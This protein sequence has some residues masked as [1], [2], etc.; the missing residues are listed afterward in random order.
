LLADDT[1]HLVWLYPGPDGTF[2]P[3]TLPEDSFRPLEDWVDYVIATNHAPLSAWVEAS[4]F[5]FEHFVCAEGGKPPR[6]PGDGGKGRRRAKADDTPTPA[7][8]PKTA[9]PKASDPRS[10][11]AMVS[12]PVEAKKPGEWEVRRKE[13]QDEFLSYDG[14]LDIPERQALWPALA[15]ANAGAN[16]R[17]E[18]ALCWINDLWG[19]GDA[20]CEWAEGWLRSELRDVTLPITAAE[21]DR[22]LKPTDPKESQTRQF[23]AALYWLTSQEPIPGWLANRLPA[24]K[25]YLEANERKLPIRANWLVSSRLAGLTGA[26]TLGLARVRDR[27]LQRLLDEGIHAERDLPFFLRSAGLKNSDRLRQVRAMAIELHQSVRSW[28]ESS[29][30]APPASTQSDQGATL[31]YIDLFFAFALAKLGEASA[32]RQ[33]VESAW[34]LLERF[35]PDED[36]GIAARFL[37]QAFKYRVEQALDG[38]PHTGRLSARLTEELEAIRAR[39]NG[40]ANNPSGLAHYV[41]NRFQHQSRI[42]EPQEKLDPYAEYMKHGDELRKALADLQRIKDPNVLARTVR[43]LYQSGSSGKP[44]AEVRF[45]V[46]HAALLLSARVGEQFAFELVGLV[47]EAMKVSTGAG[48]A[49]TELSTK[50]GQ[51]LE[52][53]LFLAAHFDRKDIVQHLVD[54]FVELLKTKPAEQQFELINVVATQCLRSLRRLQL[55]DEIDKFL[56]RMQDVVLGGQAFDRLRHRHRVRDAKSAGRADLWG[57]VLQS[58]LHLAG[59]WLTFGLNDQAVPILDEARTELIGPDPS[60]ISLKDYTLLAQAYVAAVGHGPADTGLPRILEL[61]AMM[62]PK[63]ITNTFTSAKFYSRFHLN[64]V[65]ETVLALVSDDFALGPAGR[66]WLDEDEYLIRRRIHSDMKRHLAQSGL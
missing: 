44:P 14:P 13:L 47:P 22:L 12:A 7:G 55:R 39:A 11:T 42:L 3:E 15:T 54:Q 62:D 46:L 10:P 48:L 64:L 8:S 56:K 18:A 31:A 43:E 57:K 9:S 20:P 34:Q 21:F 25:R 60:P 16:D 45:S 24:V 27:I 17:T 63:R 59:G 28:A 26:D 19:R 38:K 36:R 6:D 49:I 61:F 29:L 5:D 41:I 23:A 32:A 65:E 33:L 58:L 2:T 52:Q 51:L 30:R 40:Q 1:D 66:R 35:K 53:A 37:F 4:R 50:Q